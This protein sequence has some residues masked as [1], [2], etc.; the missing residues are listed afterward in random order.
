IP[1]DEIPQRLYDLQFTKRKLKPVQIRDLSKMI[2]ISNGAN[3]SVPGAGK[4]TVAFACHLITRDT[5]TR[6]LVIAPKNAFGAWDDVVNDCMDESVI[7]DWRFKSLVGGTDT[8]TEILKKP[9]MR[10]IISY[11][12]LTRVRDP[13]ARLLTVFKVHV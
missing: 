5:D 3:F 11:D 9:P 6:L 8:I 7:D 10:M 12:Q 13:I 2:S 1:D 4:T